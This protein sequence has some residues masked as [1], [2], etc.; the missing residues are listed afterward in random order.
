MPYCAPS[1]KGTQ[2]QTC[3]CEPS[4]R[5]ARSPAQPGISS[6][7]RRGASFGSLRRY[8]TLCMKNSGPFAV[9]GTQTGDSRPRFPAID[10][11]FG[12]PLISG[13]RGEI[14]TPTLALYEFR[15]IL[16]LSRTSF[17]EEF[18]RSQ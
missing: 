17:H 1:E 5:G 13:V 11:R 16:N 6:L 14:D 2:C 12:K 10:V 9:T 4:V 18:R 15:T 3:S 8:L 7:V